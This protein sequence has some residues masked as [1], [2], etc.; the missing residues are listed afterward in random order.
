MYRAFFQRSS[1]RLVRGNAVALP[2]VKA[3]RLQ[4]FIIINYLFF[5]PEALHTEGVVVETSKGAY[6]IENQEF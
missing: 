1:F 3:I 5:F 6:S 4:C 2:I